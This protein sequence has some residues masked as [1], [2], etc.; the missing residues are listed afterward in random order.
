MEGRAAGEGERVA[1]GGG[2]GLRAGM[3][4]G[5]GLLLCW[6]A[7]LVLLPQPRNGERMEWVETEMFPR[8]ARA[9]FP[10]LLLLLY[11]Q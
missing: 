4:G 8:C 7:A 6:L 5:W 1:E 2:S 11:Y 10:S 3:G 9:S